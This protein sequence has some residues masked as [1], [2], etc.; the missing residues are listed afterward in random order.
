MNMHRMKG[1]I[2][3]LAVALACLV[4][5]CPR[6]FHVGA[7]GPS[8]TTRQPDDDG[9]VLGG[10]V[11]GEIAS[12]R[13]LAWV[14]LDDIEDTNGH[15]SS[16]RSDDDVYAMDDGDDNN[17]D[18]NNDDD[19]DNDD[20]DV[21]EGQ[22]EYEYV[23]DDVYDDV[24]P[25]EQAEEDTVSASFSKL[26]TSDIQE[27]DIFASRMQELMAR[28]AKKQQKEKRRRTKVKVSTRY[29]A[30]ERGS[31][32][33]AGSTGAS[34]RSHQ[35]TF[36]EVTFLTIG[37][38]LSAGFGAVPFFF[39]KKLSPTMNGLATAV[40]CGVMFAA[41]FDLIHEG[42]PYGPMM[43][44][45]GVGVGAVFIKAMQS[46]LDSLG[47]VSFG[48]LHGAKAKRLILIVGIMAAHAIG[49]GCG[50]GVSFV[51]EKGFDQGLLTTLAIGIHN[52]P[53]G[54]AKA[55]VLV[56]QGATPV[57][58]LFWS[59]MTCLPQPLMAIP[60]FLFVTWFEFLLPVSLGFAAGCMI[61]MVFAELLPE[62]LQDCDAGHVA[63]AA[64]FSAAG[65]EGF[66]ML[67]EGLDET[68]GSGRS[69]A[70]TDEVSFDDLDDPDGA[71][72]GA[73]RFL[74]K[75]IRLSFGLVLGVVSVATSWVPHMARIANATIPVVL[76]MVSVVMGLI[77][78]LPIGRD[79]FFDASDAPRLHVVA[80]AAIGMVGIVLLRNIILDRGYAMLIK[81]RERGD[82]F[83]GR[84]NS[85]GNGDGSGTGKENGTHPTTSAMNVGLNHRLP[86]R[87][88][89]SST[90][91]MASMS[92][93]AS[94]PPLRALAVILVVTSILHAM[95]CG[96]QLQRV[97]PEYGDFSSK[98]HVDAV[99][100][101][102]IG[103]AVDVRDG[104]SLSLAAAYGGL[105]GIVAGCSSF[106]WELTDSPSILRSSIVAT[107]ISGACILAHQAV[108]IP[109]MH[110][111]ILPYP[112][113]VLDTLSY[114]AHGALAMTALLTLAVGMTSQPR[115]TRFGVVLAWIL[116]L[117][118]GVSL[119]AMGTDV[120]SSVL[121]L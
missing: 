66:R 119:W 11:L 8:S 76:G 10:N 43:V 69:G 93:N 5:S 52:I 55:T 95:V 41:S 68:Y 13:R 78:V 4:L 35:S 57:E 27:K 60:S 106:L 19:D 103:T 22:N 38:A 97:G 28:R 20:D 6:C 86:S 15:A 50:V 62:A 114:V 29:L 87:K 63:S 90:A 18:K 33:R 89:A 2:R 67:M 1:W 54:M 3:V 7:S 84:V 115:Y 46:Y 12:G 9:N 105:F 94:H 81:R 113:G 42:Q 39:V 72:E 59:V 121:S 40:A 88:Y 79:L 75:D 112:R 49:E 116:L 85:H 111:L 71:L 96:A 70:G 58:A 37:M 104:K 80:A 65:L 118:W 102:D 25:G 26:T 51:G 108:V 77:G 91:S 109:S 82:G 36:F 47:D 61:W 45:I 48:K 101:A 107:I 74:P 16:G 21:R 117:G 120:V 31:S 100:L 23:Y 24:Y 32:G 34:P 110:R 98:I 44:I 14:S 92:S 83:L 53:E 64:T 56:S 99:Y 17:D 30:P 73:S